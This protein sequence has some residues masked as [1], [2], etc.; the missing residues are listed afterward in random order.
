MGTAGVSARRIAGD[1][2]RPFRWK[3]SPIVIFPPSLSL[4]LFFQQKEIF[5]FNCRRTGRE[6]NIGNLNLPSIFLFGISVDDY[7]SV[8]NQVEVNLINIHCYAPL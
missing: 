4:F 2:Y 6:E 8:I 5:R 7:L 3:M 1:C